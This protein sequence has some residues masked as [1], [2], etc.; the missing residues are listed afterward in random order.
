MP[1]PVVWALSLRLHQEV[2]AHDD[3]DDGDEVGL[4]RERDQ[5]DP[6]EEIGNGH[7]RQYSREKERRP[8]GWRENE[9]GGEAGG[10]RS[11]EHRARRVGGETERCRDHEAQ[12]ESDQDA[13]RNEV[14]VLPGA[15][16][17]GR[18]KRE[19][20][21][22]EEVGTGVRHAE[23]RQQE[24]AADREENRATE[25]AAGGAMAVAGRLLTGK[26]VRIE[27]ARLRALKELRVLEPGAGVEDHDPFVLADPSLSA[28]L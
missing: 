6:Q 1:P 4:E 26:L 24:G 2:E 19:P 27:V 16:P 20:Q 25:N 3:E 22:D 17:P 12:T 14:D 10:E 18:A 13:R 7:D 9:D 15:D 23:R 8:T 28:Q 11:E 21:R 5:I